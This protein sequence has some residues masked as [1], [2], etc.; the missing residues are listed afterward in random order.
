MESGEK[1][2]ANRVKMEGE[3]DKVFVLT[4]F[5]SCL[6]NQTITD[7]QKKEETRVIGMI[8][9]LRGRL[10]ESDEWYPSITHVVTFV[11]GPTEGLTE[12]MM[13]G[14]AAG[15]WVVTM[16]YVE[17]SYKTGTWLDTESA[18]VVSPRDHVLACRERV[19]QQGDSG[20]LFHGMVA[21]LLMED[22]KRAGVYRRIVCAGGGRVVA[23][24]T[25]LELV[26]SIPAGLTHVFMDPWVG[27]QDPL[28][29]AVL[30]GRQGLHLCDYM[31]LFHMVRGT[32]NT[33]E[34]E[35]CIIGK[36]SKLEA[37]ARAKMSREKETID[38]SSD[39]EVTNLSSDDEVTN[40]NSDDEIISLD[41][42]DDDE[43]QLEEKLK[44]IENIAKKESGNFVEVLFKTFPPIHQHV[45][46]RMNLLHLKTTKKIQLRKLISLYHPD[47]ID[48]AKHG[49]K[50]Y[51]SCE[52]I[53]AKLNVMYSNYK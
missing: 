51:N 11:R 53:T 47:K 40:L 21:A 22:R 30:N 18:Y 32:P 44:Q 5:R 28:G 50:Y 23:A 16:R 45:G 3:G 41:S 46:K 19:R 38:L 26:A 39:D 25:L 48:K 35:W 1:A 13:A 36:K 52:K 33:S 10:V 4:N 14:I 9:E 37:I 34:N 43:G 29:F 49:D 7:I 2:G 12:R 15:K 24:E 8:R 20:R 42:D 6:H 17:K 31:L 27:K